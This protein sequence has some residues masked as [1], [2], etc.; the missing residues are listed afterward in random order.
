MVEFVLIE[1][2]PT[3]EGIWKSKTLA[4]M[5]SKGKIVYSSKHWNTVAFAWLVQRVKWW[6]P[7]AHPAAKHEA[8]KCAVQEM[9]VSR[10]RWCTAFPRE[11]A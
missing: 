11:N 1:P 4:L 6:K 10:P 3:D 5:E 9:C 8:L 7:G 2:I